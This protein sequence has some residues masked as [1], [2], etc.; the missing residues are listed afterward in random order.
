[1]N[2]IVNSLAGDRESPASHED[3]V[4]WFA[5]HVKVHE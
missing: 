3:V 4:A 1:M 5:A 2:E